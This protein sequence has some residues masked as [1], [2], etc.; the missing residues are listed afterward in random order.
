MY[1]QKDTNDG[2]IKN[3]FAFL[4]GIRDDD[5]QKDKAKIH[6]IIYGIENYGFNLGIEKIRN[7]KSQ[8]EKIA[9]KATDGY[10]SF[11]DF[12]QIWSLE[13]SLDRDRLDKKDL[14]NQIFRLMEELITERTTA[15]P[16]QT[17]MTTELGMPEANRK[18][19]ARELGMLLKEMGLNESDQYDFGKFF[20]KLGGKGG[21]IL[22]GTA[23]DFRTQYLETDE[24][25]RV[26]EEMIKSI[27]MDDSDGFTAK[28]FEMVVDSYL[29]SIK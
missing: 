13:D 27:N 3:L 20:T 8:L 19:N 1:K 16:K 11:D 9:R 6:D 15:E 22:P 28:E 26:A 10:I 14:S 5:T 18:I 2:E 17:T 21:S 12:K 4:S 25:E 7:V 29:N 24:L 23:N